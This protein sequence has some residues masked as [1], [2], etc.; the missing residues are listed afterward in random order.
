M[1]LLEVKKSVQKVADAISLVLGVEVTIIDENYIRVAATGKYRKLI[2]NRI[3]SNSV[4]EAIIL[5]KSPKYIGQTNFDLFCKKC[6]AKN[7]CNELATIG[8]PIIKDDKVIGIIGIIAFEE[9]QRQRILNNHK[10]LINFLDKLSNLMVGTLSSHETIQKLKIQTEE[11]KKII[12]SFRYGIL[13]LDN[14]GDIKYI[15]KKA[16]NILDTD[17]EKVVNNNIENIIPE[18]SSSIFEVNQLEKKINI[19]SKRL[20]IFI[21]NNPVMLQGKRVSNIIELHKT[22]DIIHDAYQIFE[23]KKNIN[24]NDIIGESSKLKDVKNIAKQVAN[25]DSTVM[26]YGESGTGKELFA[27]AI[28][29]DSKR[30]DSPFIAINCASIPDNLLESELFGYEGGAFSGARKEGQMGKFELANGGTVFLDEIGDMPLH[31]QPKILRVLQNHS[32]TRIGGKELIIV[33]IR[34]IAATNRNLEQMIKNGEFREDLYYRLSVIPISLPPLRERENDILLLS[35]FFLNKYCN[36]LNTIPKNFSEEVKHIFL[37]YPWPGNIRELENAIEY[38]VNISKGDL[39]TPEY[40]PVTIKEKMKMAPYGKTDDDS[41][42]SQLDKYEYQIL[43]SMLD[44]YGTSTESKEKIAS[45]LDI[46]L[47]TFYR[48]LNKYNLSE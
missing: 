39:I 17:K 47:S 46:N 15:N 26:L 41:L 1:S 45:L 16:E 5:D 42:K 35:S 32:F 9:S 33:D 27:R 10:S 29:F 25:T 34:I 14:N 7:I 30:C 18:V 13:C 36:K 12:D 40:L 22:S 44:K 20:S 4:F 38:M 43:S 6:S 23:E 24:F 28:H 48:K 3:P 11:T 31:L 8:Y 21:R 37:S 2:G 19:K